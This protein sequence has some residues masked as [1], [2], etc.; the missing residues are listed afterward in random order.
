MNNQLPANKQAGHFDKSLE[1]PTSA[2]IKP[3]PAPKTTAIIY[4]RLHTSQAK[5]L[6]AAYI[7]NS[8]LWQSPPS[9][10][11]P[12]PF[13]M[14]SRWC[15]LRSAADVIKAASLATKHSPIWLS[16]SVDPESLPGNLKRYHCPCNSGIKGRHLTRHRY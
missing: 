11:I 1:K 16:A 13:A 10:H 15:Q 12:T 3:V 4:Q 2:G 5:R 9:T 14:Y 7:Y 6:V 8:Y